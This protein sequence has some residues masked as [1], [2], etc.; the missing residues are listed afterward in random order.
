MAPPHAREPMFKAPG[1]VIATIAVFVVVHGIRQLVD[2]QT[3]NW[4]VTYLAFFPARFGP[5]AAMLPG[6]DWLAI[7][8]LVT[9][10]VLHGDW[11][12]LI[13]N[14][15]W[16]LAFGSMIAVRTG[17]VRF[18]LFLVVCSVAGALGFLAANP[19][20]SIPIVGASG[21]ISGLMGA[22]FRLL[23]SAMD[24]GGF[25]LLQ[26]YPR[27]VPRMPLLVALTDR[28]VLIAAGVWVGLNLVFAFGLSDAFTDSQIAWEAHLGGFFAGFLLF[29]AFDTGRSLDL[30][31]DDHALH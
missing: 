20:T 30:H 5:G 8:S 15:A 21:A 18:V 28:R 3:D 14:S 31:E 12:H 7:T 1:I 27:L 9:Y 4:I 26:Q 2:Q 25:A 6:P 29:G 16:F 24:I 23:F 22:A 13:L 10:A 19:D 17:P 11:M